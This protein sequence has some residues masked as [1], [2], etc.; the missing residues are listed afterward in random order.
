MRIQTF[1]DAY[2]LLDIVCT[3]SNVEYFS[4]MYEEK[5]VDMGSFYQVWQNLCCVIANPIR[6][7]F[8]DIL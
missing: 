8:W 3:H 5:I 4:L 2:P 6:A 7:Q 1:K